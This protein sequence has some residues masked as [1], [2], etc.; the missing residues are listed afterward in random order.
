MIGETISHY[1]ILSSLGSGGMGVVYAAE[2]L[3]LERKVAIKF[4]SGNSEASAEAARRL[5]REARNLSA[6]NHPNICTIYEL[7]E[8]DGRPYLV[9]ELLVGA[10]LQQIVEQHRMM[11]APAILD[12]AIQIADGLRAAHALGLIHR[13][14]KP[15]NLFLTE[16][17]RAKILDFGLAGHAPQLLALTASA[18]T[19][20]A[21]TIQ[22][23]TPGTI[24]GTL[25]YMSPE[26]LRG[27]ALKASSDIFS[28]GL[29]LYQ[30]LV[31]RHPFRKATILETAS[32]ILM[33]PLASD[34]FVRDPS[35]LGLERVI[36]RMLAKDAATRYAD[37]GELLA[38]LKAVQARS[39][40]GIYDTLPVERP[41][42]PSI[43]VLPF[44]NLSA[45]PENEYFCE[46]LAEELVSALTRVDGLQVAAWNSAFRV[47]GKDVREA[48]QQL[49]VTAVLEGS[50]R[51]SGIQLRVNA[52]LLDVRNGLTLWSERY[53]AEMKD[54]FTLQEQ[55]ADAITGQ[56]VAKMGL[57]G[58]PAAPVRTQTQNLDAYNLYLKGRYFWNRRRPADLQRAIES[59]ELA[60]AL[61]ERYAAALAGLADCHVIL[62]IQ[63]LR[64][65]DEV[66]PL[67]RA[68]AGKA[69]A[70][71]PE[72]PEALT[73]LACVE[74]VF[75]WNWAA[76]E[77]RFQRAIAL[78]PQ[79]V[80]A[81][82]W[83]AS[84]LLLPLGRFA[85]AQEQI[86]MARANDPLSLAV[87][88][89]AG[90]IAYFERD[91]ERAMREYRKALEMDSN[92]A[93]AH[94][95]LGQTCELAGDLPQALDSFRRALELSPESQEI[96]AALARALALSG[97][98]SEAE[99]MLRRLAHKTASQY[100]SPVLLA[101]VLLALDSREAALEELQRAWTLK[102]T[103][104]IWLQVRPVFDGV[105][106]DRRVE[107]ILVATGLA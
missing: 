104:L 98:R 86:E 84:N 51:K 31:G 66:Y 74:A 81:H 13:D 37:G 52:R 72:M 20:A 29:V 14:I 54:V 11:P 96:E 71:E 53:D 61:D 23:A 89:V 47:Q 88:I 35:T 5:K 67:A 75:D 63:G 79:Y 12:L 56:L 2:D 26:Q 45:D 43:A 9:Q 107:E 101:Q 32:A 22:F 62:G 70:V 30:L 17:Q 16:D 60:I 82:H 102:S 69:L 39:S 40:S 103:D 77:Q 18:T 8:H 42:S 65:P 15:A 80:T 87:Q 93:L 46:G 83:Y 94:Y 64:R 78:N 59:F 36:A 76:A 55:M 27:E 106:G 6:L 33:L 41:A 48:G 99:E 21:D 91:V 24:V 73:T 3:V 95:F 10:T 28:L 85:E 57:R 44:A 58:K 25:D 38:E 49:G 68:A 1:R 100:V 92:F 4:L 50:L 105:R 7:G 19:M 97:D 90:L 34:S